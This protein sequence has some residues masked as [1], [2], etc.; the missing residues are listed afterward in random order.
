VERGFGTAIANAVVRYPDLELSPQLT[1]PD[2]RFVSYEL[3]AGEV[4][5]EV[6]H[7]DYEAGRCL[8]NVPKPQ[9]ARRSAAVGGGPARSGLQPLAASGPAR[10]GAGK[11]IEARCE[12]TAKP[13][14]GRVLG[15]V[16]GAEGAPLSGVTV[17]ISGP[18][19][20]TIV[21]DAA[22]SFT[23]A[24][25]PAGAYSARVDAPDYLLKVQPFTL[26]TGADASLVLS[27]APKPKGPAQVVLTAK[28]VKINT[29]IMFNPSS[30]EIDTRSTGL[31]SEI[32][33]VLQRNPQ[34]ARV[35]VQGHTD[36]RGDP[37]QNLALSQQRAEAVVQ[38]L[39]SAGI[40]ASRLEA[41]GFGDSR[42]L[43]P[44]L[45]PANRAQNRRVQFIIK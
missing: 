13:R 9:P 21:S 30:A 42:P 22:G 4:L 11:P 6:S 34:V 24:D 38:W 2:G 12:L 43:V 25:L 29:A 28:E 7:P 33:D 44:N 16:S 5:F 20:R 1:G 3:P 27:L 17:E 35:Q 45:T 26:E 39:V 23:I 37:E 15:T 36:N 8:A 14:S 40:D 19:A 10:A 41:K 32:A 31:L 18:A